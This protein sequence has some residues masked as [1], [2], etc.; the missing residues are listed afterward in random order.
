MTTFSKLAKEIAAHAGAFDSLYYSLDDLRHAVDEQGL[1]EAIR[2]IPAVWI[3][4]D[5]VEIH[6][7]WHDAADHYAHGGL[8]PETTLSR[9]REFL[10]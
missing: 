3:H 8:W 2:R 1:R 10:R 6:C 9:L 4:P 7:L 5:L